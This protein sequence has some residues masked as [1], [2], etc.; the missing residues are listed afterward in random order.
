MATFTTWTVSERSAFAPRD[1]QRL[2]DPDI[3]AAFASGRAMSP[4]DRG[5]LAFDAVPG[6]APH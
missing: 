3:A 2:G 1:S 4:Q 5:T 6:K